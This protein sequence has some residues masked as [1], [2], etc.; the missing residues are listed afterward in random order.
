[1]RCR[2]NELDVSKEASRVDSGRKLKR[3]IACDTDTVQRV[4][5]TMRFASNWM[6]EYVMVR[7]PQH[8]TSF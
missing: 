2:L 4:R 3:A 7:H 5:V 1:M 8:R 6:L